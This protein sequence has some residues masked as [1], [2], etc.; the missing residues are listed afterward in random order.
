MLLS[1]P[2]D[3]ETLV[4]DD[5]GDPRGEDRGVIR[6]DTRGDAFFGD[7][8]TPGGRANPPAVSIL[9]TLLLLYRRSST[10]TVSFCLVDV[11]LGAEL[12]F[13]GERTR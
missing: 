3:S 9:F 6:G 7:S 2:N 13:R 1:L 5:L 4:K 10:V 12:P 11:C 8:N